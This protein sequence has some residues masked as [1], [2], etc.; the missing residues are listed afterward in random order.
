MPISQRLPAVLAKHFFETAV[1]G[2]HHVPFLGIYPN[3]SA[4]SPPEIAA[5]LLAHGNG[6]CKLSWH[7]TYSRRVFE[8]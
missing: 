5:L 4:K 7:L 3:A 6:S 2:A 8:V 1:V